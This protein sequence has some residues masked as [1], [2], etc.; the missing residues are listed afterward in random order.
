MAHGVIKGTVLQKELQGA[1]ED[2]NVCKFPASWSVTVS[3][4]AH[5]ECKEAFLGL[6]TRHLLPAS[7][8]TIANTNTNSNTST[9]TNAYTPPALNVI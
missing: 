9:K 8:E 4:S 7:L 5:L 2:V 3:R 1:D 6:P